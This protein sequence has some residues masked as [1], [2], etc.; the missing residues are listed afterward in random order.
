M[1]EA[2]AEPECVRLYAWEFRRLPDWLILVIPM[3]A[4][5]STALTGPPVVP[6]S[7]FI[8][9]QEVMGGGFGSAAIV[10]TIMII[11]LI[12]IF[13]A[14]GVRTADVGLGR[15][16]LGAAVL[17]TLV[18]WIVAVVL[19]ELASNLVS[20]RLPGVHRLWAEMGWKVLAGV[21]AGA[22]VGATLEEVTFRGILFPQVYL[23]LGRW[24]ER[25]R[26]RLVL[27][28]LFTQL[29]FAVLHVPSRIVSGYYDSVRIVILDQGVL[30][31][32]GIF[33][34]FI[35]LTTRNLAIMIG[36][37]ALHNAPVPLFAPPPDTARLGG[38]ISIIAVGVV[39]G[40]LWAWYHRRRWAT[41]SEPNAVVPGPAAGEPVGVG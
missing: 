32:A 7:F 31:F 11:V 41:F 26:I 9:I 18:L 5:G 4:V 23:R 29:F 25:R 36:I 40:L 13:R 28:L 38:R 37:H 20:G 39:G 30:L 24:S 12:P 27:A 35:L 14:A 16:T 8:R 10:A 15:G 17:V 34:V 2:R 22:V 1:A 6:E 21:F 3:L 19:V 33:G